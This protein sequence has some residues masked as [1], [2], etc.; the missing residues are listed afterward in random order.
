MS[1]PIRRNIWAGTSAERP[2]TGKPGDIYIVLEPQTAPELTIWD[3]FTR[4]WG[5]Y[6]SDELE[7][8]DGITLGTPAAGRVVTLDADKKVT[9]L[10]RD[11]WGFGKVDHKFEDVTIA[12]ADVLTL[13]AT[14]VAIT[15]VP[16]AANVIEFEGAIIYK[17]AGTA[18][19]GIAA[20]E[21]LQIWYGAAG[22]TAIATVETVGFLDQ[23]TAEV[24]WVQRGSAASTVDCS[25]DGTAQLNVALYATILT[26]EITTGTSDLLFR[27]FYSIV[28][29]T[30]S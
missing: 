30:V 28:P 17:P 2:T 11:L 27:T 10:H 16:G 4:D 1:K 23:A 21:N 14:P 24:R 8:F 7:Y 25:I 18:Y 29:K 22:T 26:G 5:E 19:A 12:T 13:N 9:T 3:D 20:G 15:A 6:S